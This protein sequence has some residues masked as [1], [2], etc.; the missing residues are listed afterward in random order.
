MFFFEKKNNLSKKFL[1]V[2]NNREIFLFMFL[3]KKLPFNVLGVSVASEN[4]LATQTDLPT[5]R[6][7]STCYLTEKS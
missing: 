6:A 3:K 5:M 4:F 7:L 2:S 1:K